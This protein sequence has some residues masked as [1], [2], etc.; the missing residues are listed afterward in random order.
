M[1]SS[2][3]KRTAVFHSYR[4]SMCR[5]LPKPSSPPPVT[6]RRMQT[7]IRTEALGCQP[8]LHEPSAGGWSAS[9]IDRHSASGRPFLLGTPDY[10]ADLSHQGTAAP[11]RL[12]KSPFK[13]CQIHIEAYA[14]SADHK[15]VSGLWTFRPVACGTHS[16]PPATARDATE[17]PSATRSLG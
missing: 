16:P 15:P 11:H 5:E 12:R 1:D 9:A 13:A 3:K 8:V 2:S 4:A 7:S 10:P 6:S 17:T 14:T